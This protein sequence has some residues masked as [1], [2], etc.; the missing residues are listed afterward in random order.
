MRQTG[1]DFNAKPHDGKDQRQKELPLGKI[2]EV[3][4]KESFWDF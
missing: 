3:C 4:D 2:P 1:E